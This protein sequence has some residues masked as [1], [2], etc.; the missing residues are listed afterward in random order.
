MIMSGHFIWEWPIICVPQEVNSDSISRKNL[1]QSIGTSF[2]ATILNTRINK[3]FTT[4]VYILLLQINVA[5]LCI[6]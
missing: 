4:S 6:K 5:C 3:V 2:Y 1:C